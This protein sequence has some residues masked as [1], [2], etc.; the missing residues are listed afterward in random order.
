MSTAR[1]IS[2][3]FAITLAT[4]LILAGGIIPGARVFAESTISSAVVS[5]DTR[6]VI[7]APSRTLRVYRHDKLIRTFPVG[8]GRLGFETPGGIHKVIRKIY[9]PGWENP[10]LSNGEMRIKPGGEN[11]LG[12]RWIGFKE[13]P[14]GEYG[15]HGTDNP[16]SVGKLSSHGC[17][18][19]K[20]PDAEALFDLVEVGTPV[21]IIYNNVEYNAK[22]E[23][24][25]LTV[26]PDVFG[27]GMPP[28]GTVETLLQMTYPNLTLD[29]T[30]LKAALA[31]PTGK[32]VVVGSWQN[33]PQPITQAPSAPLEARPYPVL[34]VQQAA[35]N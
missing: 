23:A 29:E 12:T 13:D 19:M 22:G 28:A 4:G 3:A 18:R 2:T 10:Y 5:N 31:A 26:Y 21:E 1:Y 30:K 6:V 32:P 24:V 14:K 7:H 8:V 33:P 16:A 11:P 15:I 25:T 35:P 9:Q 20:V 17:V 27:K 34:P